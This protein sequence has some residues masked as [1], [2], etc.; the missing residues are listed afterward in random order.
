MNIEIETP[1]DVARDLLLIGM[2]CSEHN[3]SKRVLWR[4]YGDAKRLVKQPLNTLENDER[5][6]FLCLITS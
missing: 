6:R 3:G 1:S 4:A 2:L 5:R